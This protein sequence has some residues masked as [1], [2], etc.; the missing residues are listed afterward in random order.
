M[1]PSEVKLSGTNIYINI[2]PPFILAET[3]GEKPIVSCVY[4]FVL[5]LRVASIHNIKPDSS[6]KRNPK[7]QKDIRMMLHCTQANRDWQ[8][9]DPRSKAGLLN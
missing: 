1:A 9:V 4:L 5:L 6:I 8:S 7:Q 3:E 2:F